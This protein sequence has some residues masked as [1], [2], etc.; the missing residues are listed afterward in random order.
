MLHEF[1]REKKEVQQYNE[2]RGCSKQPLIDFSGNKLFFL[3]KYFRFLHSPM[4]GD[5]IQ[6]Y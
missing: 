2:E 6:S 5:P 4:Y 1:V 3:F